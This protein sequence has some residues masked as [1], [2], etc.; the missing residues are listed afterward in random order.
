VI[1]IAF[2]RK[3]AKM[4]KKHRGIISYHHYCRENFT[5]MTPVINKLLTVQ[6]LIKKRTEGIIFDND[7]K[8]CYNII[9]SGVTL[10]SLRRLVYSKQSVKIFVLLWAQMEHHGCTGF[11]VSDK[12]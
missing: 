7:S 12:T 8:G 11:G 6:L 4:A 2:T 9:I 5:C 3:I 10:A 1:R